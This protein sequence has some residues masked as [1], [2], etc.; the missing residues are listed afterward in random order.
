MR[1]LWC[2]VKSLCGCSCA[3]GVKASRHSSIQIRQFN[4]F[5]RGCVY[6]YFTGSVCRDGRRDRIVIRPY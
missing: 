5:L 2:D 3:K 1:F 4:Y 6:G